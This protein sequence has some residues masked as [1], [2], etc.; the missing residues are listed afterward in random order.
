VCLLVTKTIKHLKASGFHL[1]VKNKNKNMPFRTRKFYIIFPLVILF[2]GV[3]FLWPQKAS[4]Y[5]SIVPEV[6][7]FEDNLQTSSFYGFLKSF[8]G[9]VRL[10]T[11][12][13]EADGVDEIIVGAGPGGGPNVQIFESDGTKKKSFMAYDVRFR[14]GIQVAGCDL[15]GDGVS[16]IVTGPGKGGGPNVKVFDKMGRQ[17]ESFMAYAPSFRGGVNVACGDLT[18]D[19]ISEIITGPGPGGGAHV[20][21]FSASGK[22]LGK[23]LWPF[24]FNQRGGVSVA[25]GNLSGDQREE[26]VVAVYKNE[27]PIVEIY[28]NEINKLA[29]FYAYD[30]NFRGGVNLACG[31]VDSDGYEEIISAANSGGGPHVRGFNYDGSL[32]DINFFPYPRNFRGGV[33]LAAG[34]INDDKDIEIITGPGF[35]S[36][37]TLSNSLKYVEI[38]ISSQRLLLQENG[39]T[40]KNYIISSGKPGMD[41]PVGTYKVMNKSPNAYSSSYALY[42]PYWQQF[43]GI[44]HGLHGL[45]YW[46]LRSGGIIKE[47]ENH[48]GIRVSHGCVRL[49]W[50]AAEFVYNFTEVGTPIIIHK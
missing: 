14:K 32:A 1:C 27:R 38:D 3:I 46:K 31:D 9:G 10:A 16:E 19:G 20:R 17:L 4:A 12:D 41:T 5:G 23:D 24:D 29:G 39:V 26:I 48:L 33:F 11:A 36:A 6:K 7:I 42:M 43:T 8:R 28:D 22:N 15:T 21:I 35:L 47:G 44:G 25:S 2:L 18:G 34:N 40:V 37:T 13:V 50:E 45:P 30:E 49:S